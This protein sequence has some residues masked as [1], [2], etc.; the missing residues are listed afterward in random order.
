LPR[1]LVARRQIELIDDYPCNWTLT[2]G[3]RFPVRPITRFVQPRVSDLLAFPQQTGEQRASP[4]PPAPNA[5]SHE[6][7]H[8][9]ALSAL[10]AVVIVL[11]VVILIFVLTPLTQQMREQKAA[12]AAPAQQAARDQELQGAVFLVSRSGDAEAPGGSCGV[13]FRLTF[14]FRPVRASEKTGESR[15]ETTFDQIFDG[16]PASDLCEFESFILRKL[17]TAPGSVH[18]L[19]FQDFSRVRVQCERQSISMTGFLRAW[20]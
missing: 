14:V 20:V 6:E 3:R 5:T 15:F 11:V 12:D 16:F 13:F 8:Q 4:A 10:A 9:L 2:K 17:A 18:R 19:V 7:A 1:V